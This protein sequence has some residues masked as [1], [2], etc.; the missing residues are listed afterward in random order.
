[1][2]I[3][4]FVETSSPMLRL[5]FLCVSTATPETAAEIL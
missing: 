1:M 5:Y 4:V 3:L 2:S